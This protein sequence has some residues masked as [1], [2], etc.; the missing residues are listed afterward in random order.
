MHFTA[1]AIVDETPSRTTATWSAAGLHPDKLR[2]MLPALLSS[3]LVA[4]GSTAAPPAWGPA[5]TYGGKYK[6]GWNGLARKPPMGCTFNCRYPLLILS[7][8][9]AVATLLTKIVLQGGAG[10]HSAT[11]SPRR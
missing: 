4:A 1:L 11:G 6:P 8:L 9:V 5:Y 3:A 7:P 2:A 10:T